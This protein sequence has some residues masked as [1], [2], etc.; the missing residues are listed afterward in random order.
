MTILL[1]LKM[2]DNTWANVFVT[3]VGFFIIITILKIVRYIKYNKS[4]EKKLHRKIDKKKSALSH[5]SKY[6]SQKDFVNKDLIDRKKKEL[7]GNIENDIFRYK[8]KTNK[9][10]IQLKELNKQG[11]LD[12]GAF[13]QAVINIKKSIHKI[14]EENTEIVRLANGQN[15]EVKPFLK[16]T[17]KNTLKNSTLLSHLDLYN[18]ELLVTKEN[19]IYISNN[20][21]KNVYTTREYE[22]G[23]VFAQQKNLISFGDILLKPNKD[24]NNELLEILPFCSVRIKKDRVVEVYWIKKGKTLNKK[25]IKIFQKIKNKRTLNDLVFVNSKKSKDGFHFMNLYGTL[26][27]AR[28]KNGKIT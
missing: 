1:I 18:E 2:N 12:D 24:Y 22:N 17:L 20:K 14:P 27:I 23:L 7:Y 21:I 8:L 10:Y 11:I 15:L 26:V 6:E 3:C 16:N 25:N 9:E 28:T 13:N 4:E 5:L 19:L